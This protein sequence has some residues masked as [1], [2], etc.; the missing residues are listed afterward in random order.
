MDG[1]K[2]TSDYFSLI[3]WTPPKKQLHPRPT[4]P[5]EK[6]GLEMWRVEP[7]AA[8]GSS[9]ALWF[10]A[11]FWRAKG[12]NK[13]FKQLIRKHPWRNKNGAQP[14]QKIVKPPWELWIIYSSNLA[15]CVIWRSLLKRSDFHPTLYLWGLETGNGASE[16]F[17]RSFGHE[18]FWAVQ[19]LGRFAPRESMQISKMMPY[20]KFLVNKKRDRNHDL[21]KRLRE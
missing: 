15:G 9:E 21:G 5:L 14:T 1:W 6:A 16:D 10:G 20:F 12:C 4:H 8:K 19:I 11:G 2:T 13:S 7:P 3:F 17:L 18:V